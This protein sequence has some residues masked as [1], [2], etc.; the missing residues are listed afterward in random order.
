[1][2]WA[3]ERRKAGENSET[4]EPRNLAIVV[5]AYR[6][7]TAPQPDRPD[8]APPERR[9]VFYEGRVQGVGFR[10]TT[11]EIAG[12]HRV[13]GYV[14]NLTDGRVGLEVEGEPAELDRFLAA[15]GE[16]LR[17]YISHIDSRIK[18]A[19]GEFSRFEIRH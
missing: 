2:W 6:S 1:M 14:Q 19:T 16:R 8:S 15:V 11:R 4:S 18:P 17:R 12:E 10:Y 9:Q 3:S 5:K 13:L 7:M